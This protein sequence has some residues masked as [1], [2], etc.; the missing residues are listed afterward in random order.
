MAVESGTITWVGQDTTAESFVPDAHDVV[1]LDGAVVTPAFVDAHT[2]LAQ[3]GLAARGVDLRGV[4]CAEEVLQRVAAHAATSSDP[5]VL[6][7]GWDDAAW[8]SAQSFG[9][10]QLDR[11]AGGRPAYLARV[12]VH[13]ALVSSAL[14]E[15]APHL[16]GLPGWSTT[17]RVERDAHHA[18]RSV[19]NDLVTPAMRTDAIRYALREAAAHGIGLVHELGA[20]H[21]SPLDDFHRI[22]DISAEEPVPRV[23]RYWGEP[24]A[25]EAATEH[26]CRG[27]AGDL[28]VDGSIGSRT[29]A[30]HEPYED[31][32]ETSG[33]VYLDET[34]VRDHI[35]GC[36]R[37]GLQGGFHVIGDRAV[38]TVLA[39][40]RAAA[41]EVGTTAVVQ[42]R[43]RFEH[44]EMVDDA[45]IA[46][47]S[48]L[49]VIASVQPAFDALWGGED[50]LYQR[51]L[52]KMRAGA[53]NPFRSMAEAGVTLAFGS[54]TPVTPLDPWAGVRAAVWHRAESQRLP[55][56]A[57]FEA[58]TR[59]GWRAAGEDTAGWLAPGM[60]AT[61]AVWSVAGDLDPS[62]FPN[63]HP[64]GQLPVC[65]ATVVDG[66]TIHAEDGGHP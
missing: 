44:L 17:G 51:R 28:C 4:S 8:T 65:T 41:A 53:M 13:S 61:Y 29:A 46:L 26:G 49:G 16:T 50:G 45:G 54:D 19:A 39:G 40:L 20:P 42:A 36:T 58:H 24:G 63:L 6:G 5:I 33:H 55:I 7:Y 23:V 10:E 25:Y 38:D 37:Q 48:E 30:L 43:H 60:P 22:S 15:R 18:A 56:E 31:T 35:V 14:I 1:E 2:H 64:D 21:L 27:L 52:G 59:G 3:T 12:D 34:Q 32:V 62:G 57:A 47:L 11:A 9:R 66:V